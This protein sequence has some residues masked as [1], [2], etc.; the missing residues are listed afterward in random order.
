MITDRQLEIIEAAGKILTVS[1]ISGLTI[2]NLAKEMAFTE[3]A[4]YRHFNS[5]E[6]IILAM[7]DYL[8]IN[9]DERFSH[10][11]ATDQAPD[12]KLIA[13]FESQFNFFSQCPH[14]VIAVF[15]EGLLEESQKINA[16]ILK[17]MDTKM[18]YVMPII[19]EG[20]QQ[21]SFTN[22]ITTE[23]MIQIVMGTFRLQMFKWRLSGFE[24]D[25]IRQGQNMTQAI[26]TLIK[27]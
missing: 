8:S 5:K 6:E 11:I 10:A 20:Q 27:L 17:I 3:S 24:Y 2:K 21:K 4:I 18:K 25:I 22:K 12:E 7:L 14:F 19:R 15:S 9:M 23:E 1:G 16:A 26:L 13:L